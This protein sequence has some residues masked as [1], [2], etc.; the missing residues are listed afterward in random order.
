M[1]VFSSIIKCILNKSTKL[2]QWRYDFM[3]EIFMIYMII[4]TRIN[5]RQMARYSNYGEQRFRN[6]YKQKFDFMHFNQELTSTY[7]GKRLAIAF[8]PSY[9]Q[10]S[11][12]KT[13]YMGKFCPKIE[14]VNPLLEV[15]FHL[16]SK[17]REDAHFRYT[18]SGIYSG[19][20]RPSQFEGK[21][22][23]DNLER[24]IFTQFN[25]SLTPINI[26]KAMHLCDETMRAKPFSMSD[27]KILFHNTFMLNQF[28]AT[29]GIQPKAVKN[30]HHV[31][32]LLYFGTRAS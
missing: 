5:F 14:V 27:Y 10:K 23:V 24:N 11:G 4:P 21:V 8:D 6:Q 18:F 12:K 31:K 26:V 28:I 30:H 32:E 1:N 29:F 7:F 9:I 13:L 15:G 2:N 20:G 17:F 3:V 19:K 16:I 25:T 22:D